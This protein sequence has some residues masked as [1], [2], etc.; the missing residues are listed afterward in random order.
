MTKVDVLRLLTLLS[1]MLYL[2]GCATSTPAPVVD[3]S[4]NTTAASAAKPAVATERVARKGY[5]IVKSGDTLFR[6]ALDNGQ[7]Y[8]DLATWNA[9]EDPN[10]IEVGR[11][12]RVL[13]PEADD[14]QPV[15][16]T[17]PVGVAKVVELRTLD[18]NGE[19]VKSSPKAGREPYSDEAMAR[20]NKGGEATLARVEVRPESKAEIKPETKPETGAQ[21]AGKSDEE[22]QWAWPSQGKMAGQF[23][24]GGNKGIDI[25]G[26]RGE[27]VLA[28]AD[29]K[30]VYSGS[31]L[32]GYGQLL[33]IKH[34]NTFLTA[35]AHN[36]KLLVKEGDQVT[37]GK[38]IAEMGDTEADQVKLHFEVRRQGK[39]VDPLKHLPP[40]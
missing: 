21:T 8:R 33:I 7:A 36:S 28:A 34:N 31:G 27:S 16:V 11:E 26:K 24:E 29:G 17:K 25:L 19:Q 14:G 12:L 2:G 1:V 30:V 20:L 6:I 40:R 32:R 35:Y 4:Q 9:L 18:G 3:R 15:V 22:V 23:V 5:Y 13:P 10:K 39:P 37:R 38:K